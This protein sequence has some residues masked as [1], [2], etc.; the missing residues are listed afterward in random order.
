MYLIRTIS[1]KTKPYKAWVASFVSCLLLLLGITCC[2]IGCD[3]SPIPTP[4]PEEETL[5]GAAGMPATS[6]D[7]TAF[8]ANS[9]A[10]QEN[11]CVD[12]GATDPDS[13]DTQSP[14]LS[15]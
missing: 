1:D 10:A 14:C 5:P 2:C 7:E 8:D 6:A 11:G 4:T 9:P 12:A 3:I 13:A 15:D